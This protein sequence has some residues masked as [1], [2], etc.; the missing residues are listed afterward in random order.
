M[1]DQAS[2]SELSA[3]EDIRPKFKI[4]FPFSLFFL[5]VFLC[6]CEISFPIKGV[7]EALFLK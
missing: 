2:G 5:L 3:N 7:L 1:R 4:L 6:G